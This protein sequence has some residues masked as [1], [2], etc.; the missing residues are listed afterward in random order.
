MP[1]VEVKVRT[2]LRGRG[3]PEV[4][5]EILLTPR[6]SG[7]RK[8]ARQLATAARMHPKLGPHIRRVSCGTSKINV[9]LIPSMEL[10][11]VMLEWNRERMERSDVPGQLPLFG[12]AVLA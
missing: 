2:R 3:G 6:G 5:L 11:R 1:S 8:L 12:G 4:V 7:N 9:H 10:S